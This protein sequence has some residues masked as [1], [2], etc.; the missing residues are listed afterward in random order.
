MH[1]AAPL[2]P[3]GA[4][5]GIPD[6]TA[7]HRVRKVHFVQSV[8]K[9][10][11][12]IVRKLAANIAIASVATTLAVGTAAAAGPTDVRV[13]TDAPYYDVASMQGMRLGTL[14]A[15]RV[16]AIW[17]CPS[18]WCQISG[19]Y[20]RA[21]YLDLA[22]LPDG[23]PRNPGNAGG[24]GFRNVTVNGDVDLYDQPGGNG[25]IVGMLAMGQT[26]GMGQ[27]IDGWCQVTGGWVWG[28][29]LDQ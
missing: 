17:D 9:L 20:V 27:C 29:F 23:D 8:T 18:G 14:E 2:P 11:V 19:G 15:G 4:I 6:R 25:N 3:T 28:E 26:I 10:G 21:E 22:A 24:G 16:V 7:L 12:M 13:L 5:A 1:M